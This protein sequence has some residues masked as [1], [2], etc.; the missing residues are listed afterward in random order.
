MKPCS[1]A[2]CVRPHRARGYCDSHYSMARKEGAIETKNIRRHTTQPLVLAEG[3]RMCTRCFT[4][5]SVDEFWIRRSAKQ[6]SH[7][8]WCKACQWAVSKPNSRK[9]RLMKDFGLTDEDYQTMLKRQNGVCTGCGAAP[10][11]TKLCI[12][13]DHVTG[14]IRGLLCSNCNLALGSI[15]DN[16]A[17]LLNLAAYLRKYQPKDGQ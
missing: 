10:T 6:P 11:S 1:V 13:H 9:H 3:Y 12:D 7:Q 17:T 5:K 8:S 4:A 14:S 2:D 16:V 15:K